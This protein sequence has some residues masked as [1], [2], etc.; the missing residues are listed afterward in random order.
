M[1][2][3]A[4]GAALLLALLATLAVA[5]MGPSPVRAHAL[6]ESYQLP[7]PLWLYLWGAFAAVAA[8]FVIVLAADRA[9][10][11]TEPS[12]GTP[13]PLSLQHVASV[14]LKVVGLVG[15]FT[16]MVAGLFGLIHEFLP[17]TIFWT[18]FWAG[19]PIVAVLIGNP[20][21]SMSPFR[22]LYDL[23]TRLTRRE[24]DLGMA[25]PSW[26]GR[27]PAVGVLLVVLIIE[28]TVSGSGL[29]RSVGSLI[30]AYT[31]FTLAGMAVFG[32]VA[33]LRNAEVFEVL[34]GWFGRLAPIGRVSR[35]ARLCEGCGE[36]CDPDDCVDCPECSIV[37]RA[38]ELQIVLRPPLSGMAAVKRA[39]W[40]DAVF[41]VLALAGVT[42][43]GF[44]ETGLWVDL[45]RSLEAA[46]AT[47]L[48]SRTI[49]AIS[50]PI[51]LIGIWLTFLA[52][53]AAGAWATRHIGGIAAPLTRTVGGWAASLLPIA[54]GYSIAHYG[55]LLVQGVLTLPGLFAGR[56]AVEAEL[57]W[58]P[59]GFVW[60]LS[61]AA[62]VI[63][64]V[65]AVMLAHREGI[66]LGARRPTLAELPLVALMLGYTVVSL[67]II[68]QPIT[69][70]A[71]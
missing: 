30:L 21:P 10:A 33:W 53:F 58:L 23:V 52:I 11:A 27:W 57:G 42:Y 12:R 39:G 54:A 48:D 37:A 8:S 34:L 65:A 31:I 44:E 6:D 64:H 14:V 18:L 35:S 25:Y 13:L 62:I 63:G 60:Y 49:L 22:T 7:L 46:L 43:D 16:A 50:D 1:R 45:N 51:G 28:L 4:A 36:A 68:A 40:S 71:P 59:A 9:G 70:E 47:V 19:L 55:T 20:W 24:P 69:L 15:W 56:G 26:A 38:G 66:R 41:I 32:P 61:V 2:L 67:W 3:I 17:A 5:A 29:G